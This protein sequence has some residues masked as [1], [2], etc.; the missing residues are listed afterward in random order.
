MYSRDA[1]DPLYSLY[2]ILKVKTVRLV[3][4]WYSLEVLLSLNYFSC[5]FI[6]MLPLYLPT[7]CKSGVDPTYVFEMLLTKG[8]PDAYAHVVHYRAQRTY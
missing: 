6:R 8:K 1:T 5:Y 7:V 3:Q 4:F 2:I